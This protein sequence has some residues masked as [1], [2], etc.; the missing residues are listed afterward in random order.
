MRLRKS[1]E[2]QSVKKKGKRFRDDAFWFQILLNSDSN[3][4]PRLGVIASRRFGGAIQR[5]KA[6]RKFREIFRKNIG[7]FPKGS[8]TVLLP[9]PAL[10]FLSFEEVEERILAAISKTNLN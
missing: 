4:L 6:K 5:N 3:A 9:R 8:Q 7:H 2:Y 10:F 1:W